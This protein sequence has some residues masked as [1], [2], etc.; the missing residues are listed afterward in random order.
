MGISYFSLKAQIQ[1]G[2]K[3]GG[4]RHRDAIGRDNNRREGS[5]A[6]FSIENRVIGP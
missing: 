2:S 1:K 4:D 5:I 3:I 6:S